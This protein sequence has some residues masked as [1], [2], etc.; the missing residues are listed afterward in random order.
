MVGK[1]KRSDWFLMVGKTNVD[2]R[3]NNVATLMSTEKNNKTQDMNRKKKCYKIALRNGK[4][5]IINV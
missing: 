1:K 3:G 2:S 5:W 4:P